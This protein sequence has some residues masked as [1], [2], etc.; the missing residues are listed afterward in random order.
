MSPSPRP[1]IVRGALLGALAGALLISGAPASAA[2]STTRQILA[3]SDEAF[4]AKA[5]PYTN[6]AGE[7]LEAQGLR[8][9]R[10]YLK[11]RVSGLSGEVARAVLSLVPAQPSEAGF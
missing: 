7:G 4:V 9:I 8:P 5:H 10:T 11:F 6:Y 2:T 3:P 1:R